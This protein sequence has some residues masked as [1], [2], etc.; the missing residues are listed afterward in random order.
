MLPSALTGCDS[1][2][3]GARAMDPNYVERWMLHAIGCTLVAALQYVTPL[4]GTRATRL[5]FSAA[6]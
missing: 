5:R 4:V 2:D 6:A 1:G 3:L